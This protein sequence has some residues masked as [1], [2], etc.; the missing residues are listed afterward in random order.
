MVHRLTYLRINRNL[1]VQHT[2]R[3]TKVRHYYLNS[4]IKCDGAGIPWRFSARCIRTRNS[5]APCK[6]PKKIYIDI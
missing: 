2:S 6:A 5:L 3:I 4:P 1:Q